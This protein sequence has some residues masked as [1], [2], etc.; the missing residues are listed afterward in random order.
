MIAAPVLH[1]HGSLVGVAQTVFVSR[2]TVVLGTL[3]RCYQWQLTAYGWWHNIQIGHV[4]QLLAV[5]RQ[6]HL[7]ILAERHL[8]CSHLSAFR[9]PQQHV[10]LTR[11]KRGAA[12][13]VG[14]LVGYGVELGIVVEFELHTCANHRLTFGIHHRDT[15]LSG[16]CIVVYHVNL[17]I[18]RCTAHHLLGAVVVAKRLGVHQHTARGTLVKPAQVQYRL[19]LAGT[20]EVPLSVGPRLYPRMVIV[21]VRPAR[22]VH[23]SGWDAHSAQGSHGECRL[24]TTATI[25]SAKRCQRAAGTSVRRAI[26]HVL[27]TPMVHFEDSILHTQ[28][29]NSGLQRF[30][31]HLATHIQVLVVHTNRHHKMTELALGHA[32]SPRHDS[33]GLQ[34]EAYILLVELATIVGLVW[35][36]HVLVEKCHIIIA[37]LAHNL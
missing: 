5:Q 25:G 37:S 26:R 27:V 14:Q 19:W 34:R 16:R 12:L 1:R 32:L 7:A 8:T 21:G 35:Q 36:W 11:C 33:S 10:A 4:G 30:V 9:Y 23:L 2:T 13:L 6:L 28:V 20:K 15:Y 18:A 22:G 29:L 31:E 3:L 17:G 24:L